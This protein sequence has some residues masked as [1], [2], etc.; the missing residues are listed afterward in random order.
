MTYLLCS[1]AYLNKVMR[2]VYQKNIVVSV[3]NYFY[4]IKPRM[5]K[6]NNE[7]WSVKKIGRGE[8]KRNEKGGGL[9][10]RRKSPPKN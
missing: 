6:N 4:N 10:E 9:Y 2:E 1:T 7:G 3:T 5:W 8:G